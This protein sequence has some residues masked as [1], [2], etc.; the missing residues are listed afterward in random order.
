KTKLFN[1][2]KNGLNTRFLELKNML[3]VAG[4]ITTAAIIRKESRGTH[5]REDYPSVNNKDWLKHIYFEQQEEKFFT[6]C[7]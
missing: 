4:L 2:G 3:I 6:Y 7:T 5:Y 1:I